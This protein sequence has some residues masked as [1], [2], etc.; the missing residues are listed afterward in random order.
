MPF[1]NDHD[2]EIVQ[3]LLERVL[4][5]IKCFGARDIAG[6]ER[7]IHHIRNSL[8]ALGLTLELRVEAK[9]DKQ[10]QEEGADQGGA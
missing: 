10:K 7:C 1:D 9:R 8:A 4:G 6:L 2:F 5:A 3:T